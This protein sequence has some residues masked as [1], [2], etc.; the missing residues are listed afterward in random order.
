MT[1]KEK[2]THL[3]QLLYENRFQGGYF[4]V[5]KLLKDLDVNPSEAYELAISLEKMGHV[6]MISTKDGTFLD[7]IAKGIEFIE[8]DN[9][10][11]EIDFFSND[12][13]KEIIKRLD[14]FFTKIEEI[15]LGQQI[16]YDDLSNEFEELKELL[17]ILN[18]KNWKEVLKGKLIDMGLGDLTSEVKETIIDVFKDNKLLN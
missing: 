15:Q 12:E 2:K 6:R 9:S 13:K 14:N 11:K 7:I 10:K 17:K 1:F 5:V 16:I 8:D 3:L 18:K 4:D